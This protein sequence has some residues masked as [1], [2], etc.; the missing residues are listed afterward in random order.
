MF[1][2]TATQVK[3][4]EAA[5]AARPLRCRSW[6]CD[7]CCPNRKKQLIA[8]GMS[9]KPNRF[10]TL[11]VNP[12][13]YNSPDERAEQL[14]RAWR[15][16]RKRM[17]RKFRWQRIPFLAVV[18][19]QKSGEPHLH[20]LLRC[21]YI[22]QAWLSEQMRDLMHAPIVDIRW[23]TDQGKVAGYVAK[24]C[25]K[26]PHRYRNTKRYWRSPDW[27]LESFQADDAITGTVLCWQ[28]SWKPI[29][30]WQEQQTRWGA[31]LAQEGQWTYAMAFQSP[32]S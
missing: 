11:T 19:K 26:E 18:E 12:A 15:L 22:P 29:D 28:V 6:Q 1:C 2:G 20:I 21:P 30:H 23:I 24:Y 4:G 8:L 17:K 27:C 14:A 25:G 13:L 31:V 9:G 5:T 16:I 10:L 7:H 3:I 32:H